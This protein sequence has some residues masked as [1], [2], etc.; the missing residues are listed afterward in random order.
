[1]ARDKYAVATSGDTIEAHDKVAVNAQIHSTKAISVRFFGGLHNGSLVPEN[2]EIRPRSASRSHLQNLYLAGGPPRLH[3]K[4]Q[5]WVN[6]C[7]RYVTPQ[8]HSFRVADYNSTLLLQ[9]RV[10]RLGFFQD[11]DIGVSVFPR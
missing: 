1:M 3:S 11:G 7:N 4:P 10:F 5:R 9:L 6:G 2:D 8:P